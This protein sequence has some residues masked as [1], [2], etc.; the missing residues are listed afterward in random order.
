MDKLP[1][2]T[3]FL[4]SINFEGLKEVIDFFHK[5]INILNEKFNDLNKKFKGF[6][7]LQNQMNE[8]K[9]KTESGLRLLGE[10]EQSIN[11]YSQNIMQNT[12]NIMTNKENLSLLKEELEKIKLDN[13]NKLNNVKKLYSNQNQNGNVEKEINSGD[14]Y[15][16]FKSEIEKIKIENK[17]NFDKLF[18]K[19]EELEF[20]INKNNEKNKDKDENKININNEVINNNINN[21]ENE[22]IENS[23]ILYKDLCNKVNLLEEK[24]NKI[25]EEKTEE[26]IPPEQK[27]ELE[28]KNGPL[29]KSENKINKISEIP[30]NNN[31]INETYDDKLN[32]IENK[33]T[34]LESIIVSLQLKKDNNNENQIQYSSPIENSNANI[35]GNNTNEIIIHS[36]NLASEESKQKEKEED[37][38]KKEELNEIKDNN[39]NFEEIKN[40]INENKNQIKL[41]ESKIIEISSQI[42]EI[43][44]T[45]SQGKFEEKAEFLKYSKTIEIQLKDYNEKINKL[46]SKESFD[47]ELLNKINRS[48][49]IPRSFEKTEDKKTIKYKETNS[50]NKELLESIEETFHSMIQGYLQKLDISQNPKILE[51]ENELSNQTNLINDLTSKSIEISTEN[52]NQNKNCL[53]LIENIK[54]ELENNI[55][56]IENQLL[57][58]PILKEELEFCEG[59]LFGKEEGEKYKKMSKEERRNELSIGTSVKE[60]INIHGNYLKKLSEGINKVNNR[61]NNLNKENLALIKKDLKNESNFILEDF[62]S[63][64]K[65]SIS[66]IEDQLRDKVDKLGLDQFWNKINDQLIEEMKQKIDKKELNKNNMYLKKKIDNLESKI[67]RTFVDTLIDLQMDEAPLLVKKNFREITEQKCASCGQNLQGDKNINN[68]L[69][70]TSLDFN[71]IGINQHKTYRQRNISDKDKLPEIKTN[72]QNK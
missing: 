10:L 37:K 45:F 19:V 47:K 59:I 67:S 40:M 3:S 55:K 1:C 13:E 9:I 26:I 49:N 15:T 39:E 48:N 23:S 54:S 30:E 46:L 32:K 71:N 29:S 35:Y 52:N 31:N 5:N 50:N 28:I 8:N 60:E 53:N 6:E 51:L 63:G 69:L 61:I 24:I 38:E 66:K 17:E 21:N 7:D 70:G 56:K 12:Q 2:S 57:S 44:K 16:E 27:K 22:V 18:D 14:N 4:M 64:L 42:N 43:N 72:L 36:K 58:F 34:Y 62:K 41:N 65:E 68:G 33:I 25:T 11:N 20:K